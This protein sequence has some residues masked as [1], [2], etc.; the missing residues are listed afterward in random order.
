[1]QDSSFLFSRI[2]H[3]LLSLTLFIASSNSAYL[4]PSWPSSVLPSSHSPSVGAA[5]IISCSTLRDLPISHTSDLLQ[6]AIG[7]ISTPPSPY[8][9]IKSYSK[10]FN[11]ISSPYHNSFISSSYLIKS[12]HSNSCS[13]ICHSM[14]AIKIR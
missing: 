1:M 9:R 5:S 3:D 6:S 11:F 13:R 8:F 12:G 10:I 4:R 2:S 7:E 14:F